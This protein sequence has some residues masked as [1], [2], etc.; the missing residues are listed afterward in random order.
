MRIFFLGLCL[1]LSSTV[2]FANE[3]L[4]GTWSAVVNGQPM[5]VSFAKGGSG[6]VDGQPMRWQTMGSLLFVD[7][8]GEVVSYSFQA[9]KQQLR[10]SGDNLGVLPEAPQRQRLQKLQGHLKRY[11]R[12]LAKVGRS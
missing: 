2:A 6:T 9:Q 3:A 4:I 11:Q 7:Q 1:F 5:V 8:D 12:M 10:V